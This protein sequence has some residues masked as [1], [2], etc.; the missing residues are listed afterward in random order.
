VTFTWSCSDPVSGVQQASISR[1]V[2]TEGANQVVTATCTDVA[3]N[4]STASVTVNLDKTPPLI[5]GVAAPA[6]PASGWYREPVGVAFTCTDSLSGIAAGYPQGNTSLGSDTPG[7]LVN[8]TCRDQAGNVA[9]VAVG[10]IR[11]DTTPPTLQL[12]GMSPVNAAGWSNGPATV[13][14][15]CLDSGSGPSVPTVTRTM[16]ASGSATASCTDVAGNTATATPVSVRIDATPPLITFISPA[17]GFTY[18]L[19]QLVAAI[20]SCSD[21]LSGVASCTGTLPSGKL[22]VTDTP[23]TFSFTVTAVDTA[24][25]QTQITRS[26]SILPAIK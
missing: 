10:P 1:T 11:I 17:N 20:Y 9:T 14:W 4:I 6:A 22:L 3:G 2:S 23:G 26:Y 7:T 5:S 19:G 25:N 18:A 24:G 15:L 21:G 16:T 12:Q 13:T 8:G